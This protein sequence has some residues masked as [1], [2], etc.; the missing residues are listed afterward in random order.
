MWP[1]H[2]VHKVSGTTSDTR[3]VISYDVY[4]YSELNAAFPGIIIRNN[5]HDDYKEGPT[6]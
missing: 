4:A 5:Y 6:R 3:I 2:L 1:S